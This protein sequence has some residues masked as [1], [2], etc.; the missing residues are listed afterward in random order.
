MTGTELHPERILTPIQLLAVWF[1]VMVLISGSFLTAAS[2]IHTPAWISGMLS[3]AAVAFVPMFLLCAILMQTKFRPQLQADSYYLEWVRLQVEVIK[4]EADVARRSQ[5][6]GE[7]TSTHVETVDRALRVIDQVASLTSTQAK[8]LTILA[9]QPKT[10][11]DLR[12]DLVVLYGSETRAAVVQQ[13]LGKLV[14]LGLVAER[15]GGA[16]ELTPDGRQIVEKY[17]AL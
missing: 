10:Y 4:R 1:A 8:I 5:T 16:Y 9:E 11:V 7:S 12:R 17:R 6:F 3:I 13:L 2:V 15:D 14:S